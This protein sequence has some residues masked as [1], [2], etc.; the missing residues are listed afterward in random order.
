MSTRT[1]SGPPRRRLT[2]APAE[3]AAAVADLH[4]SAT[5][6]LPC[7]LGS[8]LHWGPAVHATGLELSSAAHDR[9]LQHARDDF[10]VTVQAGMP[11]A[12]LESELARWGQWLAIDPPLLGGGAASSIGGVVARGLSG[13][14]SL[15]YMGV[16]DRLVGIGLMR[17]D[18][19]AAHAGGRVVKNVAGY[20]LMRLLCG[21]WG[22]LALITELTLRTY[23]IPPVRR[24]QVLQAPE[25]HLAGGLEALRRWLLSGTLTPEA[26]DWWQTPGQTPRLLIRLGSVSAEAVQEQQAAIAGQAGSLGLQAKSDPEA[27]LP[28]QGLSR[29]PTWLARLAVPAGRAEALLSDAAVAGWSLR[30]GA[31][32]GIGE[33]SSDTADVRSAGALRQ[34]C[35]QLG[36]YLT[37]LVQ[38][39]DGGLPAWEDAPGRE[40]IL[41][42]KRR[43]DPLQ[44]LARGRLPGVLDRV[45]SG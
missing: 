4:A 25:P 43:F 23:P 17:S 12:A 7:G 32:S 37:L 38:P 13:G 34:L 24:L 14:L 30:L 9:I 40:V 42:L 35:E 19:T 27:V 15:R 16:R 21:S 44:Q 5:P 45:A 28:W 20:D 2:P 8:R 3:L 41:A 1:P 33:A 6:W 18:G 36:G 39:A 29:E 11:L 31:A 10:T 26:I 22:S